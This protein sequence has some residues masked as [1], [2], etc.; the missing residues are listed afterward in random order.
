MVPWL[1]VGTRNLARLAFLMDH[2]SDDLSFE[3][4]HYCVGT[5]ILRASCSSRFSQIVPRR[6]RHLYDDRTSTDLKPASR[7]ARFCTVHRTESAVRHLLRW[8][9]S[10]CRLV[11]ECRL[12]GPISS[13]KDHAGPA[14]LEGLAAFRRTNKT[15]SISRC[16]KGR[17]LPDDLLGDATILFVVDGR[18]LL[19]R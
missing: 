3:K 14:L 13:S 9:H 16:S 10:G 18:S 12:A 17:Q 19:F 1:A 11:R 6:Q 2:A 8:D 4:P 7:T 5:F 15:C